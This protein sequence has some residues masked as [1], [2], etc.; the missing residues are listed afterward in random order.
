MWFTLAVLSALFQV[1][2]NMVMKQLGHTLDE[3][4]NVWGRFNLSFALCRGRGDL[5][6]E[7]PPYRRVS[8]W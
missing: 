7:C 8:G 2:R 6:R 3:T 5:E 4:I 1:L